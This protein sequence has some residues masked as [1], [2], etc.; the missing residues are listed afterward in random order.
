MSSGWQLQTQCIACFFLLPVIG[1]ESGS[2]AAVGYEASTDAEMDTKFT[3][4]AQFPEDSKKFLICKVM[5]A[6][7]ILNGT[8][9]SFSLVTKRHSDKC[10]M[11]SPLE[12]RCPMESS[13]LLGVTVCLE[14]WVEPA[15]SQQCQMLEPIH[16]VKPEAPFGL[17]ITYQEA[18]NEYLFQ[19]S[20]PH[21]GKYSYL[22]DKLIHEIAYKQLNGN[23]TTREF[24]HIPLKLQGKEFQPNKTYEIKIRSKPNGGFFKGTWSEWSSSVYIVTA[25]KTTREKREEE[26]AIILASIFSFVLLFMLSMIPLFWKNRI[27]PIVWPTLPNHEKTLDKLCHKLRKN[28]DITFF[29]PESLGYVHI[30]KVDSIQAKPELNHFLQSLLPWNPDNSE[31]LGNGL[32]QKHNLIHIN[33]G[34]LKLPLAYEG[35]WPAEMQSGQLGGHV[36][37]LANRDMDEHA[38]LYEDSSSGGSTVDTFSTHS[39]LSVDPTKLAGLGDTCHQTVTTSETRVSK[40]EDAYV[41]M[42]SFFQNKGNAGK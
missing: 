3:C 15:S 28:S 33:H 41:T 35:M 10:L 17:N 6:E 31:K 12:G 29:N 4:V 21:V 36:H 9:F 24:E 40:D 16:I 1:A 5:G 14:T 20:T 39:G 25:T 19:F 37:P 34:W 26:H 30:H 42:T 18:A 22:K 8:F 2:G 27:K 38:N 13:D 32:E 11:E 23:W 7:E